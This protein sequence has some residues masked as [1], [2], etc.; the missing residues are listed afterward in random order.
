M[1]AIEEVFSNK[2][3]TMA[4]PDCS[5]CEGTGSVSIDTTTDEL[6]ECVCVREYKAQLK[7]ESLD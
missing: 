7:A 4:D 3:D 2:L 6:G 1:K 5:V